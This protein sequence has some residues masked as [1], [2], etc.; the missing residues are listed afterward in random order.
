[1]LTQDGGCTGVGNY[2]YFQAQQIWEGKYQSQDMVPAF[3]YDS[4]Q[5]LTLQVLHPCIMWGAFHFYSPG[6]FR[7][8]KHTERETNCQ[9]LLSVA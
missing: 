5:S 6:E 4:T 3:I 9:V 8:S 2:S 1:M 7:S